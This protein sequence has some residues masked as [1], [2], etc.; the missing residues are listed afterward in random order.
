[1][2]FTVCTGSVQGAGVVYAIPNLKVR[3]L[4][5]DADN[6]ARGVPAKYLRLTNSGVASLAYLGVHWIDGDGLYFDQ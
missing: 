4:R 6:C 2:K 3:D 1:M 5:P